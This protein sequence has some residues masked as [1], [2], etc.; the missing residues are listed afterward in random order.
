MLIDDCYYLMDVTRGRYDY[1]RLK[2]TAI[3]LAQKFRP[4]DVLIEDASTG[5]AL[6]QELK[7]ARFGGAVRLIPIE[8]DKIGRLYVNQAKF[9]AGLVLF[10]QGA[11]FLPELEAELLAFPQSKY[12][13]QVDSISQALSHKLGWD[14]SMNWT[15]L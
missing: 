11:A 5:T 2:E 13:D 10:P 12:N 7:S 1:P 3:N 14:P 6:A 9:E 15:G 4:Q 8:R